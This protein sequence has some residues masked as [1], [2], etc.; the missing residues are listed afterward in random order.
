MANDN[1]KK[2]EVEK[3]GRGMEEEEILYFH[4]LLYIICRICNKYICPIGTGSR[5]SYVQWR[6][7]YTLHF[8][9]FFKY[10]S[11]NIIRMIK[12]RRMGRACSTNGRD[13]ECI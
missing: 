7:S 3:G 4:N 8:V 13:E 10:S 2:G 5:M 9:H 11:P 12:S 1:M 6:N